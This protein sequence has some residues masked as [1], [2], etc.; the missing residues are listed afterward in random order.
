[1]NGK[2]VFVP[3]VILVEF[4]LNEGQR[5]TEAQTSQVV[6]ATA[7]LALAKQ[8]KMNPDNLPGCPH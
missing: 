6:K 1:M 8:P 2:Q 4:G 7:K 3:E 5:L